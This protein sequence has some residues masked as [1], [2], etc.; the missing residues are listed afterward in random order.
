MRTKPSA[1]SAL[2]ILTGLLLFGTTAYA[3]SAID[4]TISA[5]ASQATASAVSPSFST[6]A[7]NELLLAFVATDYSSGPNTTVTAV[8]GAGLTWALV[9]RSNTQSGTAEIW[10]AFATSMLSRV[11]V[12]ATLS[13]SVVSSITVMSFTGVDP[14]GT[15]GSGAIGAVSSANGASGAPAASLVTTRSNSLVIGV[16]NDYDHAISRTVGAA[17]VLVHQDLAPVDD[18]YWVQRQA[19]VTSSSGTL[20][21]INDTAPTSDRY[22]LAICEIL[23]PVV[24]AP[25]AANAG[26]PVSGTVGQAV[27]FSGSASGG[28]PPYAYSWNFGDGGSASVAAASHTFA[29]AGTYTVTLTV[30][31]AATNSAQKSTTATI[32]PVAAWTISGTIAPASAGNGTRVSLGGTSSATVTANASGSYT[33]AGLSNGSYVVTPS[34]AGFLFSPASQMVTLSGA[35]ATL[36]VFTATPAWAIAGSITPPASGSGALVTL[37]QNQATVGSTTASPSGNYAFA[38]LANGAYTVT[39]DKA[40]FT[41]SPASQTVSVAG[42]NLTVPTFTAT[43]VTTQTRPQ[44]TALNTASSQYQNLVAAFPLWI[45]SPTDPTVDLVSGL[46]GSPSQVVVQVDPTMG[47]VFASTGLSHF[48]VPY[49]ASLDFA[50]PGDTA[51][52]FSLS[53]WVKVTISSSALSTN[54]NPKNMYV[55]T[56]D[57]STIAWAWP[58]YG[59]GAAATLADNGP[60]TTELDVDG[61][62]AQETMFG[63]KVIN[64]GQW[65]LIV[66]TYTPAASTATPASTGQIYIDGVLDSTRTAMAEMESPTIVPPGQLVSPFAMYIGSDDD[67]QS[68][69]WQGMFC[70]LRFYNVALSPAAIAAMYAPATRWDLYR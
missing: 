13:Q 55:V 57:A 23:A 18:T 51:R 16:G 49:D 4:V 64:D 70:D 28:T 31:D 54:D 21:P 32:A 42:A 7:G 25:L 58:G 47:N 35:S 17:Q 60:I 20:V 5:D 38:N 65:H 37:T 69:P 3:G 15:N 68:N 46:S 33:F 63:N 61:H 39:P 56:F 53:V 6:A 59:L 2:L 12:T 30:T 1:T 27:T 22:N 45:T 41:F 29:T 67:G 66:V 36:P 26:S 9:M 8:S 10:R 48:T 62:Q 50:E 19:N 34:R 24:A 52:P 14:S 11:S 43:A 40:G 44:P